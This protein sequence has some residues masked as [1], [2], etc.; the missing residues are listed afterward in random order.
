MHLIVNCDF[1][2]CVFLT[3]CV[4]IEMGAGL[5][6]LGLTFNTPHSSPSCQKRLIIMD[7]VDGMSTN[8]R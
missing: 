2:D 3:M 5:S 6:S 1:V 7:E 8:D 4:I